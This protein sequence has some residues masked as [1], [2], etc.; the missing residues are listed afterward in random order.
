MFKTQ[1]NVQA[2]FTDQAAENASKQFNASSTNQTNQFFANLATQTSQFNAAQTNAMDQFNLNAVNG[3]R[4]FNANIQQQR[5]MFNAQNG[6][7]IAQA[8]AKWRQ[9][10]TTM[11]NATQNESNMDFAQTINALTGKNI[12]AI[13]QRERD[14][15]DQA[16]K[17]NESKLDRVVSVLIAD[18]TL[19]G[20]KLKIDE[21]T[22]TS[23]AELLW[24]LLF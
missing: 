21:D 23:N 14:L 10:L 20:I 6:L 5:D 9:D 15:M 13:W 1:Q 19:E 11:N 12:D 2:L 22:K 24:N 4:E 8:N 16:Y 17:V 3:L 7:V 18:K